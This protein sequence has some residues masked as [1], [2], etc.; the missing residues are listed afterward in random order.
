MKKKV[1]IPRKPQHSPMKISDIVQ[2]VNQKPFRPFIME[3][4]GTQIEVA[5]ASSVMMND[6]RPDIVVVFDPDGHLFILCVDQ[7]SSLGPPWPTQT[8]GPD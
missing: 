1:H 5:E 6:R 3:T 4:A 2:R 7:I 8:A